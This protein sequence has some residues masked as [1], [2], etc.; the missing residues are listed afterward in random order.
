MSHLCDG[1]THAAAFENQNT[2]GP[3]TGGIN[4]P[5][6]VTLA[7]GNT[8]VFLPAAGPDFG[9]LTSGQNVV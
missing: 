3:R 5:G 2:S 6:A 4:A 7:Q 1:N 9:P 8:S